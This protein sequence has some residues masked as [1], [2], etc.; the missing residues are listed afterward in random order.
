MADEVRKSNVVASN[1]FAYFTNGI[2]KQGDKIN[3]PFAKP[4][5]RVHASNKNKAF[6]NK[7]IG[8]IDFRIRQMREG[9]LKHI[10]QKNS[11]DKTIGKQ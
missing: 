6:K 10:K 8:R 2:G 9:K 5:G 3:Q 4:E 7:L 11:K 1:G